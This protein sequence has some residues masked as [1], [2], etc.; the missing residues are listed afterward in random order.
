ME[1]S[2]ILI[3]TFEIYVRWPWEIRFVTQ[4]RRVTRSRL[5]PNVENVGFLVK[6][7]PGTMRTLR[8][9]LHEG[10]RLR[11][12]PGI[13]AASSKKLNNAVIDLLLVEWTPARIT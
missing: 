6:L 12:V 10:I 5:E 1:P 4:N 2:A 13:R 9:L 7:G 11:R 8:S 3:S